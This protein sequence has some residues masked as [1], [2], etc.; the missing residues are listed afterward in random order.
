MTQTIRFLPGLGPSISVPC[1]THQRH[2]EA[3]VQPASIGPLGR[4]LTTCSCTTA[5]PC[6][7]I[8]VQDPQPPLNIC[9]AAGRTLSCF[10]GRWR[11]QAASC[12]LT[13][14]GLCNICA[15]LQALQVTAEQPAFSE[16]FRG[17][18]A[19]NIGLPAAELAISAVT[20]GN[21][22]PQGW[23]PQAVGVRWLQVL[24]WLQDMNMPDSTDPIIKP[25]DISFGTPTSTQKVSTCARREGAGG[26]A[27]SR[28]PRRESHK[29]CV[30][31]LAAS[32]R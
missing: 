23:T 9:T 5:G 7:L 12:A 15:A 11:P 4:L 22:A 20:A 16:F 2:C 25:E 29:G 1:Q 18:K 21:E 26:G 3:P 27:P 17:L 31:P 6:S 10:L 13:E 30:L 28:L 24:P 19:T 14:A 32:S 8:P